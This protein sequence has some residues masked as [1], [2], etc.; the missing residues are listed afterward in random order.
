M[1]RLELYFDYGFW[2]VGNRAPEGA[3]P[4]L[5]CV[6]DR[7]TSQGAV[8]LL[9]RIECTG[10]QMSN[11]SYCRF[12]NTLTDLLDCYEKRYRMV[13]EGGTSGHELEE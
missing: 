3:L 1:N 8:A 2:L 5:P 7:R 13:L 4:R 12:C 9:R 10:G 6:A 11:M